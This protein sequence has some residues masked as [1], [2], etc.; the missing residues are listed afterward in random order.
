MDDLRWEFV[1]NT[2]M[3]AMYDKARELKGMTSGEHGIGHAKK[4]FLKEALGDTQ[5]DLMRKIKEAFDPH[6]ILNPGKVI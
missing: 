1:V 3:Q 6:Q 4:G 2:C 5:I